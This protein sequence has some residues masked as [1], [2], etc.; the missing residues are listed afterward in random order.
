MGWRRQRLPHGMVGVCRDG[1]NLLCPVLI[2]GKGPGL[3]LPTGFLEEC[4]GRRAQI[5]LTPG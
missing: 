5:L 2:P 4:E 1:R 3:G